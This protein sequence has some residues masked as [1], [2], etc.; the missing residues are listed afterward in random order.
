MAVSVG[1]VLR[2]TACQTLFGNEVCN[3]LYYLVGIWTG[4]VTLDD[5]IDE[6]IDTVVSGIRPRQHPDLAWTEFKVEDI[7]NGLD[8]AIRSDNIPGA[9]STTTEAAPAFVAFSITKN[10]TTKLTR[11]GSARIAGVSEGDMVGNDST[12]TAAEK[13]QLED[14]LTATLTGGVTPDEFSLDPV[15]VGTLPS[16]APDLSR[17]QPFSTASFRGIS[18]QTSRK[19]LIP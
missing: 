16:G 7:T 12:L 10:R 5:V 4:N 1:D 8:F 6:F 17:V 2:I 11:S 19:N 14:A 13:A 9:N 3:V 18:T 15:I